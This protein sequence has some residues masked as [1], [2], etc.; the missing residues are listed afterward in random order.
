MRWSRCSFGSPGGAG[1]FVLRSYIHFHSRRSRRPPIKMSYDLEIVASVS[2]GNV[3]TD[4]GAAFAPTPLP[5]TSSHLLLELRWFPLA[6]FTP[7]LGK[8]C[9]NIRAQVKIRRST[10]NHS[11]CR[12]RKTDRTSTASQNVCPSCFEPLS[13]VVLFPTTFSPLTKSPLALSSFSLHSVSFSPFSS[14]PP[15]PFPEVAHSK[16][17]SPSPFAS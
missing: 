17:R 16:L 7:T 15:I 8:Q 6:A 12:Q 4:T 9:L 10:I 2:L 14:L 3:L 11:R 13:S 5:S 1:R